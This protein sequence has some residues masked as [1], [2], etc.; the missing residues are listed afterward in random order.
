M[1]TKATLNSG[2]LESWRFVWRNGFAPVM[3]VEAM[4][5]LR[6]GLRNN[7]PRLVQQSTTVPPPLVCVETWPCEAGC[8]LAY[9]G[10]I[11]ESLKTV[12]DVELYFA[13]VC[14]D[15]DDKIGEPAACRWFLNWFDDTPRDEMIRE[16]LPEVEKAIAER[17]M[18]TSA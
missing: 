12:G 3:K 5:A 7:D 2:T 17:E 16:L 1:A 18:A 4:R 9:A 14:F 8:G 11:G 13:R 15:A 10:W 6:D